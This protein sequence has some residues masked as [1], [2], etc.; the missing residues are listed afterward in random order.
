LVSPVCFL[1][2]WMWSPALAPAASVVGEGG[3]GMRCQFRTTRSHLA[4]RLPVPLTNTSLTT[5]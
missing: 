1:Q 3:G 2:E 4:E 5:A